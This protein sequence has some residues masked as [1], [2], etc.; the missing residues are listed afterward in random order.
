VANSQD[1]RLSRYPDLLAAVV[2]Y[3]LVTRGRDGMTIAQLGE[4]CERDPED[5]GESDEIATAL[6]ILIGDEL[7]V[8]E[9]SRFR[10][11]RAAIRASELT[12]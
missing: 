4:A 1:D 5:P 12:F 9:N 11:T 10:P 7:A 6:Q 8:G 2:L 3:T